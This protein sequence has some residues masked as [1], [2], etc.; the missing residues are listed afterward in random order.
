MTIRPLG[1]VFDTRNVP[2]LAEFWRQATGYEITD[3][4]EWSAHL[5]PEGTNLRYILIQKVPEE[6]TTKNSCHV[7]FETDDREADVERLVS[8]GAIKVADHSGGRFKWTVLQDPEGN[9]F[10]I[11]S[12]IG[13]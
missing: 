8:A 11:G 3:S 2:A 10:C 9:E 7:D 13:E 6:K 5:A 1:I 12:E 4:G